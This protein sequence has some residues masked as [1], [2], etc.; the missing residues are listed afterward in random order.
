MF[1]PDGH[2]MGFASLYTLLSSPRKAG[3][4]P[5]SRPRFREGSFSRE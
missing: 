5:G 3:T 1:G 4:S 2:E